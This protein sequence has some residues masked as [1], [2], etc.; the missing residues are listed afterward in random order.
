[1]KSTKIKVE[2]GQLFLVCPFSICEHLIR[3]HFGDQSY[4]MSAPGG[5]FRL[6]ELDYRE[7]FEDFLDR[8]MISQ[9]SFV[10]D[11]SCPIIQRILN[12]SERFGIGVESEIEALYVEHFKAINT[13]P[14]AAEQSYYLAEQLLIKQLREFVS[15]F[16]SRQTEM[17]VSGIICNTKTQKILNHLNLPL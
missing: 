15:Y 17:H 7:A 12:R 14:T 10:Q 1:M 4:F 6:H 9:L 5:V 13:L 8:E 3:N 11:I 16:E 2:T